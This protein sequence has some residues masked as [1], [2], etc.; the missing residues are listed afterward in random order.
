MGEGIPANGISIPWRYSHSP[1]AIAH[2]E[3]MNYT[4]KL[5]VSF[6]RALNGN[7]IEEMRR[8]I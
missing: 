1:S 4:R 8:K 7:A 3:D 2:T 6:L 5:S